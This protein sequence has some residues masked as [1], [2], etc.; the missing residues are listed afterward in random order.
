MCQR[1]YFPASSASVKNPD[2]PSLG[3]FRRSAVAVRTLNPPSCQR[4]VNSDPG[5]ATEF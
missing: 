4:H 3:A 1:M 2:K 5:A